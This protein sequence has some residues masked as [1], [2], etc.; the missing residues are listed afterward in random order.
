MKAWSQ[1][2]QSNPIQ[3]SSR[4]RGCIQRKQLKLTASNGP[5]GSVLTVVIEILGAVSHHRHILVRRGVASHLHPQGPIASLL[6]RALSSSLLT[7][8]EAACKAEAYERAAADRAQGWGT[9]ARPQALDSRAFA[10][11]HQR[12]K[13]PAFATKEH[14]VVPC[15]DASS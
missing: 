3:S 2:R 7:L 10:G 14:L 9:P 11:R 12:R 1:M 8:V 6:R 4:V 15:S 13:C 5:I